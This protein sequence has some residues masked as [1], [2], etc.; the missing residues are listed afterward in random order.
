MTPTPLSEVRVSHSATRCVRHRVYP[1][2]WGQTVPLFVKTESCDE[3][4]AQTDRGRPHDRHPPDPNDLNLFASSSRPTDIAEVETIIGAQVKHA[5]TVA[6]LDPDLSRVP[7]MSRVPEEV[8]SI[9]LSP[10]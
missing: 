1:P 4:Q 9:F 3:H 6:H 8:Q 5:K 10:A 7:D 2:A